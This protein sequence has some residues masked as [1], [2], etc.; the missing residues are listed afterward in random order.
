MKRIF[1]GTL[2]SAARCDTKACRSRSVAVWPFAQHHHRGHFL[3]ELGV[4]HAEAHHLR[5][6]R[7]V[8]QD[9]VDLARADIFS[10]PRLMISFRRPVI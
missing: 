8:H 10:P 1:L 4:R 5:H 6:R 7:V 3:A 9:L 2:K